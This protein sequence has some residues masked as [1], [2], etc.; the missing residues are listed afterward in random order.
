MLALLLLHTMMA[1]CQRQYSTTCRLRPVA[2][3]LLASQCRQ[4]HATITAGGTQQLTAT[5]APANATNQ[6]VKLELRQHR[7]CYSECFG[8][9]YRSQRQEALQLQ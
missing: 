5:I 9:G 6:N 2:L 1:F 3:P 4:Q 8:I 7:C